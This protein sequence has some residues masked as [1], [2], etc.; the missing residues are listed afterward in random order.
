MGVEAMSD[1]TAETDSL[2]K[3]T[4]LIS[5]LHH[6]KSSTLNKCPLGGEHE[7]ILV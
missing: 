7:G 5:V 4:R 2:S 6:Q 1:G 3:T